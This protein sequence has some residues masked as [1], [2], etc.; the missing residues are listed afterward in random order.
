MGWEQAASDV[1]REGRPH[2]DAAFAEYLRWY[3][4]RTRIRVSHT[5]Q[6]LPRGTPAVTDTYPRRRDQALGRAV[7]V[8]VLY[9]TFY[10][11]QYVGKLY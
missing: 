5:P 1:A 2:S 8:D 3:V 7:S 4:P 6:D 9:I 10:N 11:M